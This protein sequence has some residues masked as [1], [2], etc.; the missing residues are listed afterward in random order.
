MKNLLFLIFFFVIYTVNAQDN[1]Y[2]PSNCG[3]VL[4]H[5]NYILSYVKKINSSEWV[6]YE[7]SYP[8]INCIATKRYNY[9]IQDKFILEGTPKHNDYTNSGYDRG[10]LAPAADMC[11]SHVAMLESFYTSNILPQT[12]KL[13]RFT[14]KYL[15]YDIRNYV[16][17]TKYNLYI[18]TGGIYL[19]S[20]NYIGVEN[21]ILVP[22]HLYKII[23][24][25]I[26]NKIISFIFPNNNDIDN[27]I[28]NYQTTID[29][30]EQKTNIDFFWNIEDNKE[31]ELEK[32][33]DKYFL[34]NN[35]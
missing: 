26:N 31:I 21:K 28:L 14:W 9:F 7:L 13:N 4:K 20:T 10:H 35:F 8:E 27:K 6:C 12:P 15:E 33:K 32:R 30:I 34:K 24:D 3:T 25:D 29:E 22:T 5:E 1:K 18:I 2:I 19:D 11:F 23:Y 16:K 17:K